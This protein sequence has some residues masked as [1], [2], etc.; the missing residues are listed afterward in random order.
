VT[1]KAKRTSAGYG[2][3]SELASAGISWKK[4]K[5]ALARYI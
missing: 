3:F 2:D 5:N 1:G 4:Q